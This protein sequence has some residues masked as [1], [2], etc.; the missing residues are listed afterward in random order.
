[1]NRR[2][3]MGTVVGGIAF[4]KFGTEAA[5]G[6]SAD[7]ALGNVAR[8]GDWID[9]GL[10]DAGGSHEPYLFVVRR[11]GQ[12]LNARKNY[13]REQSEEVIRNLKDQGVEVFHTHL[14]KGF[15][16]AA[17]KPEM[18]DTVRMRPSFIGWV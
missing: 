10:I 6:L 12:S 15:G 1:M 18:E 17:E 4:A 7:N 9:N 16:M 14:Y 11:G 2:D 5:F 8:Q 13:E 3:F